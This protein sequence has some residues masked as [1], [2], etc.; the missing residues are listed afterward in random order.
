MRSLHV[1]KFPFLVLTSMFTR[2]CNIRVQNYNAHGLSRQTMVQMELEQA[3]R[4]LAKGLELA[5]GALW[6]LAQRSL[7]EARQDQGHEACQP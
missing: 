6:E 3:K 5:K 4:G 1:H 7:H 2:L